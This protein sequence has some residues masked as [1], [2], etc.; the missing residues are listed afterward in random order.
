MASF[1]WMIQIGSFFFKNALE[2][3]NRSEI[4]RRLKSIFQIIKIISESLKNGDFLNFYHHFLKSNSMAQIDD[5]ANSKQRGFGPKCEKNVRN[6]LL[7][8]RTIFSR[9]RQ[10]LQI[11]QI[12]SKRHHAFTKTSLPIDPSFES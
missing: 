1:F 12:C 9:M 6:S 7:H 3:R 10:I 8:N 11:P 4:F 2:Y 5:Q